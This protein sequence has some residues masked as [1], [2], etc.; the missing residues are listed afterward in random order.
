LP[1]QRRLRTEQE[2]PGPALADQLG[3]APLVLLGNIGRSPLESP[4]GFGS[5]G[6]GE[7]V[8]GF[9]EFGTGLPKRCGCAGW[10]R[11]TAA[12]EPPIPDIAPE[13]EMQATK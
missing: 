2:R 8:G 9:A 4:T 11:S 12:R 1:R 6:S 10:G 3:F 5:M 7:M 13:T